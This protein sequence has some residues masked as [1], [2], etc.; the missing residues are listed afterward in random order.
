MTGEACTTLTSTTAQIT[1]Q[2]KRIID[3][4]TA[5]SVIDNGSGL[6]DTDVTI[7]YLR[8]IVTKTSGVWNGVVTIT[9]SYLPLYTVALARAFE[10]NMTSDLLDVTDLADTS[11]CRVRTQGLADFS[12][13]ISQIDTL[14]TDLDS[15]GTTIVPFA[16]MLAGTRRALYI[17]L[18]SGVDFRAFVKFSD[19]KDS[20]EVAGLLTSSVS[21]QAVS[22]TGTDQTEGQAAAWSTDA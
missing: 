21:W 4:D 13:T 5:I 17:Y 16:D 6:A 3:P 14:T 22:A 11:G 10:I 8:G 20:G 19:M 12:G 15:G 9:A 1:N 18:S 2:S 7:D